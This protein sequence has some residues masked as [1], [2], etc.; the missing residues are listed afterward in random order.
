MIKVRIFVTPRG[1]GRT[2]EGPVEEAKRRRVEKEQRQ[3][4]E[5][6]EAR[7]RRAAEVQRKARKKKEAN[8]KKTQEEQRK[9]REKK[10]AV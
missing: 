6:K 2:E 10:E 7:R 9:A 4:R 3:A 1:R 8:G 5:R